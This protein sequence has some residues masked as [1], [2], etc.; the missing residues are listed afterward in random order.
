MK[1]FKEFTSN[2]NDI[3]STHAIVRASQRKGDES[4]LGWTRETRAYFNNPLLEETL[5]SAFTESLGEYF[6]VSMNPDYVGHEFFIFR[7]IKGIPFAAIGVF[8][9]GFKPQEGLKIVIVTYFP[10]RLKLSDY[11]WKDVVWSVKVNS[12]IDVELT[13]EKISSDPPKKIEAPRLRNQF[14]KH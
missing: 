3:E 9:R 8:K 10:V 12:D 13:P 7:R 5:I 2:N 14:T 11:I 1:S 4:N 6:D